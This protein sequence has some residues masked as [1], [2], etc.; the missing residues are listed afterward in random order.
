MICNKSHGFFFLDTIAVQQLPQRIGKKI[1]AVVLLATA[2]SNFH[3]RCIELQNTLFF[4]RTLLNYKDHNA[5]QTGSTKK[6]KIFPSS[7]NS[8]YLEKEQPNI[9]IST[10]VY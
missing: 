5:M 10:S 7:S 9:S 8:F 6:A 3:K 4:T 1:K 2:T